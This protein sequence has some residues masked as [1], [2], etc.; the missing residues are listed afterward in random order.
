MMPEITLLG[1]FHNI[2]GISSI[3]L[4]FYSFFSFKLISWNKIPS[5]VYL[6]LTFITALSSLAIYNQ[7]GFGI[8][9]IMGVLALLAVFCGIY[10]E[11][12]KIL[13]SS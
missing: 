13:G 1:W 5:R 12:T 9:H 4:G 2:L 11:K 10:V 7:G 3:I 8:A 6:I